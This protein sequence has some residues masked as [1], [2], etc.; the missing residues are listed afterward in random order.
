MAGNTRVI[1]LSTEQV[2]VI[3]RMQEDERQKSPF[4][5]APSIHQI[6]RE[7]MDKALAQERRNN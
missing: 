2:A 1:L 6:A 7:L 4:G 3:R 5:S